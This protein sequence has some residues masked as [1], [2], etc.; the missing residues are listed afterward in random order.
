MKIR[1]KYIYTNLIWG[2]VIAFCGILFWNLYLVAVAHSDFLINEM[3]CELKNNIT[4]VRF[5]IVLICAAIPITLFLSYKNETLDLLYKYR[6]AVVFVLLFI[7]VCLEINGSSIGM[8]NEYFGEVDEGLLFGVSRGI[9]SD[10][11]AC[12]TPMAL[13]QYE[14]AWGEFSYFSHVV[15]G[16]LTDVFL[17]YGQP[18]KDLAVIFRPFHWGYL[19]LSPGKGLS[20]YWCARFLMLFISSFEMGMLVSSNRKRL[21]VV[22]AMFISFSPVVHWWFAVNGLMELLI[23]AQFS[24]V[25]LQKYMKTENSLHRLLY[26]SIIAICAGGY[27]LAMYPAWQIPIGFV[28]LGLIV[29]VFLENWK[30]CNMKG[31]DWVGLV[32]VGIVFFMLILYVLMKSK[33]TIHLIMNTVYPGKRVSTGGGVYTFWANYVSNIWYAIKGNGTGMNVCESAQF[34]DL[35][36][37]CYILPGIIIFRDKLRDKL[38]II[39]MVISIFLEL[40]IIVGFPSILA[41]IT[42]MSYSTAL[43]TAQIVGFVNLILLIR[44]LSI[45]RK[46]IGL[47]WAVITS[48]VSILCVMFAVTSYNL[49]YWNKM[50]FAISM[51][52]FFIL[53]FLVLRFKQKYA[54]SIFIF[55][56]CVILVISTL[57]VNPVR[58]GVGNI[59]DLRVVKEINE[60]QEKEPKA[61]WVVEGMDYPRINVGIMTGAPTINSTNIY[62]DIERW[63]KI[64]STGEYIDVYNR[65]AH[66]SI[67]VIE[68]DSPKFE[69]TNPDCFKVFLTLDDL[70]ELDVKYIFTMNTLEGS[71]KVNVSLLK[72]WD[73][74]K[75]YELIEND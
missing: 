16:G 18:V 23:Y 61:L 40:W 13:S 48:V 43:R 74:Y 19:F 71:S 21:A 27:I 70:L 47:K 37:F 41:Q 30:K 36:P 11:W 26:A 15:R 6:F 62:P 4:S 44:S 22:Y 65:Y 42:L 69:L 73:Q 53:F 54:E 20:F 5:Y 31:R 3:V 72:S 12:S 34:I 32:V 68:I 24:I 29:W 57:L 35:F 75:I 17:E 55:V 2:V 1:G 63:R 60:I 52:F 49:E 7:C 39:L 50:M 58:S 10:E 9:R 64:D 59:Y 56:S 66:I 33:D 14:D 46:S 28:L 25:S 8:W 51:I 45:M 67:E 38:L